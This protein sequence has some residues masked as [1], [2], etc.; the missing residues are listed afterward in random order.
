[1]EL[2]NY[3]GSSYDGVVNPTQ[4]LQER[5]EFKTRLFRELRQKKLEHELIDTALFD[6]AMQAKELAIRLLINDL[7]RIS[8]N[9]TVSNKELSDTQ[10]RKIVR[11]VE[12]IKSN[13]GTPDVI[14][15]ITVN[16][17]IQVN[18]AF[19]TI[20][21]KSLEILKRDSDITDEEFKENFIGNNII[22]YED[23]RIQPDKL[24]DI[25]QPDNTV[26]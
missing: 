8:N 24:D 1:M 17:S 14:N 4:W 7:A 9:V 15:N 11:A 16:Q 26:T 6:E 25:P 18:P 22:D 10:S 12:V 5:Y 13:Y 3:K 19:D 21:Q 20:L 2:A 23:T